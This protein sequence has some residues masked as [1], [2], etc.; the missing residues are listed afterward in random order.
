MPLRSRVTNL[1]QFELVQ[2][3]EI[4]AS[5]KYLAGLELMIAGHGAAGIYLM[6]FAAEM[7]VKHAYFRFIGSRPQEVVKA[8]LKPAINW[9]GSQVP[10]AQ[11]VSHESYHSLKFWAVLLQSRRRAAGRPLGPTLDSTFLRC[12][13]RLH[14]NWWV[15]M[16]YRPDQA[17]QQ[18]VQEV[19]NDITWLVNHATHLWS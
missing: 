4:A 2:D 7:V 15:E 19:Y 12:M 1:S 11:Q 16:R 17:T 3:L 5:E 14:E 6:G 18:E 10:L 8:L 9:F 13:L